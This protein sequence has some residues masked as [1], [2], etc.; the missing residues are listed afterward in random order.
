MLSNPTVFKY[1]QK[2]YEAGS[3]GV[4]NVIAVV[5]RTIPKI[6]QGR[7]RNELMASRP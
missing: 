7:V 2:T 1:L 6:I 4:L 3:Q 5:E